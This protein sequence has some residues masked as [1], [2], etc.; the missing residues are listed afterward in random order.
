MSVTLGSYCT[1]LILIRGK[2]LDNTV[3]KSV[4]VRNG[5]KVGILAKDGGVLIANHRDVDV[6]IGHLVAYLARSL[7]LNVQPAHK[8]IN[9]LI[10]PAYSGQ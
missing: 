5:S 2:D 6:G 4:D 7:R 8:S 3:A 9:N 1:D 10:Q